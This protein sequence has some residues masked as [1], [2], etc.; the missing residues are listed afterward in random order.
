MT[1]TIENPWQREA[2]V[3]HIGQHPFL[4]GLTRAQ[5]VELADCALTA[6]FQPGEVIFHEGEKADRFYL[7]DKGRIVLESAAGY[8][9]MLIIETIGGGDLLGWS[10]MMPPYI[11]HFTA[12]AIEPTEAIHFAG[13]MLRQYCHN[14]HS[15]GFDLHKRMSSVM[16]RRLQAARRRMLAMHA[17]GDKL[18]SSADLCSFAEEPSEIKEHPFREGAD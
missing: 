1:M 13:D 8:G 17:H 5:L 10:W 9:E 14:D 18:E 11:W 12:R 4:R 15:L 2:V 6:R 7:I 3:L 16:I